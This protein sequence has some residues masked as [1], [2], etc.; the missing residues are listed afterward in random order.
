VTRSPSESS[1]SIQVHMLL[2]LLLLLGKLLLH[3][4]A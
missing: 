2:L 3:W 1:E 4:I